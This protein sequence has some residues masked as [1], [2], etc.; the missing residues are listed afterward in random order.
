MSS[1]RIGASSRRPGLCSRRQG[2]RSKQPGVSGSQ[3]ADLELYLAFGNSYLL[4][5]NLQMV[6]LSARLPTIPLHGS[7]AVLRTSIF[8]FNHRLNFFHAVVRTRSELDVTYFNS[9]NMHTYGLLLISIDLRRCKNSRAQIRT[10]E[11]SNTY[12]SLVNAI[13]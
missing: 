1:R 4:A 13:S 8:T 12:G 9:K 5:W 11:S 6:V 10:E 3:T 7:A 2:L